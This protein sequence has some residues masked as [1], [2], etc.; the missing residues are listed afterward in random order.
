MA[1]Y[2]SSGEIWFFALQHVCLPQQNEMVQLFRTLHLIDIKL[3]TQININEQ[4][5]VITQLVIRSRS[6]RPNFSTCVNYTYIE[7]IRI[8]FFTTEFFIIKLGTDI[9]HKN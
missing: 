7:N 3:C 2:G 9:T 8:L 6:L 5:F 1:K 4:M